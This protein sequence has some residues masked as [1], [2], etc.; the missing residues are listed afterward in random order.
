MENTIPKAEKLR[1][2]IA[3]FY[4]GKQ[5]RLADAYD[6]SASLVSG[7]LNSDNE[8]AEVPV[9]MQKIIDLTRQV[10]DLSAELRQTQVGRAVQMKSGFAVVR[11]AD[12]AS[13]GTIVCEG[14]PD[15]ETANHLI[16]GL[17]KLAE[18]DSAPKEK[19]L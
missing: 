14:I 3:E 19:E 4:D 2:F 18:T 11:F 10:Q 8:K 12:R 7:W 17:L 15:P 13:P 6:V 16:A 1:A 5:K 9:Y